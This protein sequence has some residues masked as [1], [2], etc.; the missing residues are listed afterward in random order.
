MTETI[1]REGVAADLLEVADFVVVMLDAD[2][3][4]EP[5]EV[6]ELQEEADCD[7]VL[8]MAGGEGPDEM[9]V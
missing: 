7:E 4:E 8:E 2:D 6:V 5:E 1:G 9:L 3:C